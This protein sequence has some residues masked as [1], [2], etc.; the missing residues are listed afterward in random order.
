MKRLRAVFILSG[1]FLGID[2]PILAQQAPERIE[3]WISPHVQLFQEIS[4]DPPL[5][6]QGLRITPARRVR[7]EAMLGS[8]VVYLD[9][10]ARGRETTSR[11]VW[12]RRAL[13]GINADFFAPNGDP[14]GLKIIGGEIVS[15]PYP[16]RP[17][18]GWL[19]TGE[20]VMGTPTFD[21]IVSRPDGTRAPLKG[22][23]RPAKGNDMVLCTAYYGTVAQAE[24]QAVFVVLDALTRPLRAGGAA[25][26]V[27]REL[28]EGNSCPIPFTGGV[29]IGT[30]ENTTFLQNLQPGDTV[31]IRLELRGEQAELWR[32]VQEAVAGGPWLVRNGRVLA[33]S[34]LEVGGFNR[35]SFVE[36]RHPRTAIGRTAKGEV[37]WVTVDGRQAHSQGVSLAELAQLMKRYGAVEAI[38]LDGGGS[39]TLVVFNQVINSPS[40]G[41]ERAVA[42]MLLLYDDTLRPTLPQ[43]SYRIEPPQATLKVGQSTRFRVYRNEEP[44]STWEVVWGVQGGIGFVD[45]WGRFTALRPGQG[46]VGAYVAGQWLYVPVAVEGEPPPANN[47]NTNSK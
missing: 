21:A 30:G 8:D 31:Q 12:R 42:N 16:D 34:E 24:T 37:L 23:N 28:R 44:I 25:T 27:V 19:P 1:L 45:Q 7:L 36:R 13:A 9:N 20:V 11:A 10:P 6:I 41:T 22:L 32:K 15:E 46:T 26:A 2:P 4:K 29:L 39:T 40:D 43:P 17:A 14:L 3:K 35:A 38:N 33:N 5:A 18:V 47:E